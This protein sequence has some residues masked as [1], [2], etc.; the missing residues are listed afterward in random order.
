MPLPLC[1][2]NIHP[3]QQTQ[4]FAVSA[5]AHWA[6]K[7][8]EGQTA[9]SVTRVPDAAPASSSQHWISP[10]PLLCLC[11]CFSQLGNQSGNIR[12]TGIRIADT[13][14]QAI[15]FPTQKVTRYWYVWNISTFAENYSWTS[16]EFIFNY[17]T[18]FRTQVGLLV[19]ISDLNNINQ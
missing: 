4:H 9:S 12:L 2:A 8:N 11:Y 14:F 5:V 17:Y 3:F 15:L 18:W 13:E 19:C 6:G 1:I 10:L 7:A 16:I